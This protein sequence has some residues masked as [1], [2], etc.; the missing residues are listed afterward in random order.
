MGF[1]AGIERIILELKRQGSTPPEEERPRAFVVYFGKAPEY[2]D[3]AV[4]LVAGLRH[5]GIKAEMGY[6]E[7][8]A[9]SQMKQANNSGAAYA[10]VI[11]EKELEGRFVA[12][13]DVEAG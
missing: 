9:K 1:G 10:V 7:R 13:E 12:L 8:S 11:G 4:R 2:K 3:A 6:G 5:T